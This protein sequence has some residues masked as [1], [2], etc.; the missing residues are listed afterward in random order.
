MEKN[1]TLAKEW[2]KKA[3]AKNSSHAYNLLGFM[4]MHFDHNETAALEYWKKGVDAGDLQSTYNYAHIMEHVNQV[5]LYV[6]SLP[7]FNF[8]YLNYDEMTNRIIMT[9]LQVL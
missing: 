6:F 8:Q 2:L 4:A 7:L 5:N 3:V 1:I 9:T